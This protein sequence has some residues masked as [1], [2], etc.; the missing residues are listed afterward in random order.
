MPS[1]ILL[2]VEES[3]VLLATVEVKSA[4]RFSIVVVQQYAE[5]A[6]RVTVDDT[7][8]VND[9]PNY[10]LDDMEA[11]QFIQCRLNRIFTGIIC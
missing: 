10:R 8:R 11:F 4:N 1:L 2:V 6:L 7:F 3:Y 5:I 9:C